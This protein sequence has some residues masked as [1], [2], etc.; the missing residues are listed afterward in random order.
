[1]PATKLER[2]EIQ[3]PKGIARIYWVCSNCSDFIYRTAEGIKTPDDYKYCP[4]CG[5]RFQ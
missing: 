2:V 1:M 5:A 3:G 4:Y